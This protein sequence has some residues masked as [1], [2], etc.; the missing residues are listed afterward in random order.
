MMTDNMVDKV[1][2]TDVLVIGGGLGG[3]FAALFASEGG[4]R[5]VLLEK[6]DVRRSG[7]AGMGLGGWHQLLLP[8]M[9]LDD[10]AEDLTTSRRTLLGTVGYL[11]NMKGLIDENLIYVGYK[12]NW[13]AVRALERWGQT[14]KWDDEGY[15]FV[16]THLMNDTMYFHGKDLKKVLASQL[17]K[18]PVTVLERTMGVDLLTKDGVIA[19]ATALNVRTGEFMV[20]KA[21]AVVLATGTISRIFNPF[22]VT[23]QGRFRMLYNYHAG[24]GDG[25]AMAFRVGAEFINFEVGGA[26]AYVD[27][28]RC[29]KVPSYIASSGARIYDAYGQRL[30]WEKCLGGLSTATQYK[31]EREGRTPCFWDAAEFPDSWHLSMAGEAYPKGVRPVKPGKDECQ[32]IVAKY[33]KER[34]YDTRKDK[35]EILHFKPE[36]NVIF[37]G[38][39]YDEDG[40]TNV[41]RLYAAGDMTGGSTFMGAAQAAVFGMRA[42][43]H[44]LANLS[45]MNQVAIDE[46]QVAKQKEMVFAPK[47]V[48]R[49]VEPLEVEIK[50]RDIVERYCGPERSEGSINQGL[51]RLRQVRD[52]FLTQLVARDNHE[53]MSVQEVRNLFLM[54]EAHMVCARERQESGTNTYRL[55]CP[56]KSDAPWEKA[57]IARLENN[58]I[59]I[60]RRRMPELKPEYRRK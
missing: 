10:V 46:N 55:D 8:H 54:A 31:L 2:E 39:L 33:I 30:K 56:D 7:A 42:G 9:K 3:P 47:K 34:G 52:R 12:D 45:K 16:V 27:G 48:E 4:A 49:G 6:A 40:Q 29:E 24:S 60:S 20:I 13:E 58:D 38:V 41:T 44:I 1:I 25:A 35:F 19:G 28:T 32:P 17:K 23:A 36:H 26:G 5:V 37:A 50:I 21:K 43:K 18:S 57:I 11:P 59:Q 15:Y 22:L 53:L 51:W 14:M